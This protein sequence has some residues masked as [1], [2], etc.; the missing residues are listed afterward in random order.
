MQTFEN[1][2]SKTTQQNYYQ[3]N[4]Q[5][6]FEK[7]YKCKPLEIFFSENSQ[8]NALIL[9][10]NSPWVGLIKVCLNGGTTYTWVC[11]T[12]VCLSG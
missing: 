3:K 9:H 10:T 5:R 7:S 2:F 1:L 4:S 8:Q 12:K 6:Q 11:V